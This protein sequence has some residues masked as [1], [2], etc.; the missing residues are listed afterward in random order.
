MKKK[1]KKNAFFKNHISSPVLFQSATL[2]IRMRGSSAPSSFLQEKMEELQLNK[3]KRKEP[4][5]TQDK[6]DCAYI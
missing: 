3:D 5:W 6:K 1:N 2:P 4:D